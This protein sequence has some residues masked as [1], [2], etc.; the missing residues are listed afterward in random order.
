LSI[1]ALTVD[2][3]KVVRLVVSGPTSYATGGFSVVIPEL[4]DIHALH[5][6]V[7]RNLRVSNLVHLVDYSYSGNTVTFV[8]YR[9]D[10]TAT[11]PAT[12]SEVPSGTDLSA[13]EIEVVA[14]GV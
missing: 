8:V 10:V 4:A 9:I 2:G 14:V 6:S 7:R 5:V 1:V 13:L 3:K 12:W 11:A